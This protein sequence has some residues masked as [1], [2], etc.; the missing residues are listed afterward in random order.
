MESLETN[1]AFAAVLLAGMAFVGAGLIANALVRATPLH[2]TAI[3][4]DVPEAAA[5]GGGRRP[6]RRCRWRTCWPRRTRG[7]ARRR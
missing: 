2:E 4:I 6:G 1:K 5:A 7:G 3:K